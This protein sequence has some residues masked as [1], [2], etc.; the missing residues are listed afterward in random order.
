[1]LH[2]SE[3]VYKVSVLGN[4]LKQ[5]IFNILKCCKWKNIFKMTLLL[6]IYLIGSSSAASFGNWIYY[7]TFCTFFTA[8]TYKLR[9]FFL[10]SFWMQFLSAK[11]YHLN[12]CKSQKK[13]KNK[14]VK[15]FRFWTYQCY[16][17][18]KCLFI[19]LLN[20]L[21]ETVRIFSPYFID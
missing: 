1:M 3:M 6:F 21:K 16:C 15:H 7:E 9:F 11:D 18:M 20:C 10:L 4:I 19:Y 5:S 2:Q 14:S 17:F 13:K 12:F 8:T